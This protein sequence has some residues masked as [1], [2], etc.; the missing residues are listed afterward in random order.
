VIDLGT[1]LAASGTYTFNL[2]MFE[3]FDPSVRVYLEDRKTG[4]FQNLNA[5]PN[6]TFS[7]D[8]A[9]EGTR[10]R[11][12]FMAPVALEATA[13]CNNVSAGKVIVS[14]PN[15]A[16]PMQARLKDNS[17][18][19]VAA[20]QNIES[21]YTFENLM[22]GSYLIETSFDGTDFIANAIEVQSIASVENA[23]ILSSAT[24]V[25]LDQAN[26]AFT[27][28]ATGATQISWNFGD[29]SVAQ[30]NVVNH[31]YTQPGIYTVT[32]TAGNGL[33]S[34]TQSLEIAVTDIATG[35][36]NVNSQ[37]GVI[38]F[39][40]PAND[41]L[42]VITNANDVAQFELRDLSGKLVQKITLTGSVNTINTSNLEAGVYMANIRQ[43]NSTQTIRVVVAH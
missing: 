3:N 23:D 7:N 16:Y 8:P 4:E 10:F 12:H 9:F 20:Q 14:N 39:P 35:I 37:N 21:S 38:A 2:N 30:G 19:I 31:T 40:I 36:N 15:P 1:A 18:N 11:L 34:S 29:G 43:N 41:K 13:T 25:T 5:A 24:N 22:T 26:I 32:M 33:C 42:T 17:G 6:Y 28:Q 27:T